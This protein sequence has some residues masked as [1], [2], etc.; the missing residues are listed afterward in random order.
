MLPWERRS[1][2]PTLVRIT[3]LSNGNPLLAIELGRSVLAKGG[4]LEAG[5][6]AALAGPNVRRLLGRRLAGLDADERRTL[7]TCALVEAGSLTQAQAV[8]ASLGWRFKPPRLDTGLIAI[9]GDRIGFGHPLYIEAVLAA[10]TPGDASAIHRAVAALTTRADVRARHLAEA[11][12]AADEDIAAAIDAAAEQAISAGAVAEAVELTGLA[13]ERSLP[14]SPNRRTRLLRHADLLV[15]SG[16]LPSGDALLASALEGTP[17]PSE[18]VPL[19]LRLAVVRSPTLP[20]VD[21][22]PLCEEAIRL[23]GSNH[24]AVAA[25][26][27]PALADLADT[28]RDGSAT[29]VGPFGHHGTGG[30]AGVPGPRPDHGRA[31][32]GPDRAAGGDAIDRSGGGR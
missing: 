32:P 14:D 15:Q 26:G 28:A 5:E 24:L 17:E 27:A 12:P 13:L 6:R 8:H 31:A 18:R 4:V 21:I 1:L 3:T 7:L 20:A 9:D 2:D 22:R 19:L 11:S 16:D 10:A 25:G 23:A 29:S 30:T